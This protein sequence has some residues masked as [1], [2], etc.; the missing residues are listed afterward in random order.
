[1]VHEIVEAETLILAGADTVWGII[2]DGGN[3]PVWDS[4]IAEIKRRVEP[5][6]TGTGSDAGRP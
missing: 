2:P 6:R 3:Y 5:W 4:G 1:L